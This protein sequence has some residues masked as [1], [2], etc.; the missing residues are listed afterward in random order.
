MSH[1]AAVVTVSDGVSEGVREDRSGPALAA[2]LEAA[3]FRV[4]A[5]E[6]VPDEADQIAAMLVALA[7]GVQL[8]VT[9]GG[10]GFSQ[11][12]V[13]PEATRRVI[14]REAPGLGEAMRAA[15]RAKTAMADLSRGIVG[16]R[17]EALIVNTPGSVRGSSESL[18]AILDVLAHAL[19]L[20]AGNVDQHGPH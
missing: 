3:G 17:G 10:T 12:D 11:R 19:D 18:E 8:I 16:T 9:T 1:A 2:I 4:L 6:V 5:R 15:G 20:L 7:E 13:T 14:D